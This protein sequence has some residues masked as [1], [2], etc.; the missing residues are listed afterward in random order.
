[1]MTFKKS[2]ILYGKDICDFAR[3]KNVGDDQDLARAVL[4]GIVNGEIQPQL[5]AAT[6]C[7]EAQDFTRIEFQLILRLS[8][9][10]KIPTTP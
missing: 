2:S 9:W 6:F 4:A 1:M 10:L 3:K 5:Y 8:V 7:D